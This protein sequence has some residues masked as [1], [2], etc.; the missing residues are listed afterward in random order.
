MPTMTKEELRAMDV[1]IHRKV[2]GEECYFD[3]A[4]EEWCDGST[5]LTDLSGARMKVS[6]YD[7]TTSWA[8][9][10]QVMDR[11]WQLGWLFHLSA[12]C[13]GYVV[14]GQQYALPPSGDWREAMLAGGMVQEVGDTAAE[15]IGLAALKAVGAEVVVAG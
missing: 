8:G 5:L 7:Y 13:N 15:A 2:M 9:A 3:E 4:N 14:T 12:L 1:K 11:M 10:G 6:I